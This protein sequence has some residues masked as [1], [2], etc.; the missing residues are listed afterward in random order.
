MVK[1]IGTLSTSQ[2]QDLVKQMAD[3]VQDS[4]DAELMYAVYDFAQGWLESNPKQF[5]FGMRK[6]SAQCHVPYQ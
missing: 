3:A 1:G 2:Q 4:G 6:L 5:A